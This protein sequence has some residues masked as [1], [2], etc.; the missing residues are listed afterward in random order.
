MGGVAVGVSDGRGGVM[1]T[2]TE[3]RREGTDMG[4]IDWTHPMIADCDERIIALLREAEKDP[5]S[6]MVDTGVRCWDLVSVCM[7]D[8]WPYWQPTPFVF[9]YG[10]LGC[11]WNSFREVRGV[12]RRK[13]PSTPTTEETDRDE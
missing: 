13:Q 12:V 3:T 9:R 6:W 4:P 5:G 10:P 8:G 7:Y 2:W 11:E 1:R